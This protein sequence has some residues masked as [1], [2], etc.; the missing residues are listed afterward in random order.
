MGG[1]GILDTIGGWLGGDDAASED[2]AG[3]PRRPVAAEHGREGHHLG[4]ALGRDHDR[5]AGRAGH[6]ARRARLEPD[7]RKAVADGSRHLQIGDAAED[8]EKKAKA[9]TPRRSTGN[10]GPGRC[11][12][13]IRSI[14][15]RTD[16]ADDYLSEIAKA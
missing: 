10:G 3:Q 4:G 15:I 12:T 14:A 7:G 6:P 9:K 13:T 8:P 2:R 1:G 11:R 16:F 5:S